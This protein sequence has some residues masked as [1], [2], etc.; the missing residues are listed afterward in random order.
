[1]EPLAFNGQLIPESVT[2]CFL[3]AKQCGCGAPLTSCT[4]DCP[5]VQHMCRPMHNSVCKDPP[6]GLFC[7]LSIDSAYTHCTLYTAHS[8]SN[9]QHPRCQVD[10][11]LMLS[12]KFGISVVRQPWH[13]YCQEDSPSCRQEEWHSYCQEESASMFSGRLGV[14]VVRKTQRPCCANMLCAQQMLRTAAA[15]RIR[16]GSFLLTDN[17][18][19]AP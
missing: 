3:H 9:T 17:K 2:S 11:A 16:P 10:L 7:L 4:G 5:K 13:S 15:K 14:H 18:G 8:V 19:R 1:M 12:G 6:M